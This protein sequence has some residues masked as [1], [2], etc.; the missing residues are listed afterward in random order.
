MKNEQNAEVKQ[1]PEME[2]LTI[3]VEESLKLA[4]EQ[5]AEDEQG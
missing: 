1:T 2:A 3:P 5:D 4:E